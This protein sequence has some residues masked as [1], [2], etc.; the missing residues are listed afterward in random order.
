MTRPCPRCGKQM[1]VFDEACPA[2][3]KPSKPGVFLSV[4][5][6]VYGHRSLLFVAAVLVIAW[7]MLSRLI[8]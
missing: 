4:A 3:G 6:V 5:E 2:C 8:K 1:A 7:I